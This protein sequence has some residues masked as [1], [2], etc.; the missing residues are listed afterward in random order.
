M[1]H[2]DFAL[3]FPILLGDIG[4]T[5]ARFTILENAS[6]EISEFVSVKTAEFETID[7][8]IVEAV[9]SKTA[10]RPKSTILAVAGPV[11]SD[12]VPL[13]NCHWV[14]K[15]RRMIES[16]GLSDVM[17]INDFEAQALAI[18]QLSAADRQPVGPHQ[19]ESYA[20]RIVLGPGTGLGVAGLVYAQGR[21]IPV[22]GEGGHIDI[23][24]RTPRDYQIFP[25]IEKIDGRISAEQILCGRGIVH[26]YRAICIADKIEPIFT[27]PAEITAHAADGSNA[28]AVETILLFTTYLGR[29]A[30][31]VA[32][33]FMARGGVYLSGGISQKIIEA[34]ARPEF[35]AAFED[36]APHQE[37][38][39]A[40]PTFVV[41]HPQAALAGLANYA[42][43]PQTF[44]LDM[45]GKH[46]NNKV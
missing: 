2:N 1:S 8:A 4:G 34:L 11:E 41:T 20:S 35:R 30:G 9:F 7:D 10:I 42:R 45:Q 14:V 16:F 13:T 24:P 17:V 46:W 22:P 21:W 36:K 19:S 26:L 28:Q 18:A 27:D 12:E 33:L 5:N 38:M 6:C 3:P 31:D 37:L 44:G 40:I 32:L 39:R 25:Y 29:V 43:A 15:P 23:G